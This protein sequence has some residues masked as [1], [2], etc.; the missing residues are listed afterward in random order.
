MLFLS[1]KVLGAYHSIY[2][3][4][5]RLIGLLMIGEL[6][7]QPLNIIAQVAHFYT[8]SAPSEPFYE[9]NF[10]IRLSFA[11]KKKKKKKKVVP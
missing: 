8:L 7:L 2:T 11:L 9:K 1:K 3:R 5:C 6:F 10:V 4:L